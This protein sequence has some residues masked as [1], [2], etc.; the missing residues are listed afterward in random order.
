[1][2][3]IRQHMNIKIYFEKSEILRKHSLHGESSRLGFNEVIH[4]W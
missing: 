2:G 1:M 4:Q 3:L